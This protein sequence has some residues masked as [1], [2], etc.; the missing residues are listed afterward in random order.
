VDML[1]RRLRS[2]KRNT[3]RFGC[4]TRLNVRKRTTKRERARDKRRWLREIR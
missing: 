2:E 3:C 1:G 4:C